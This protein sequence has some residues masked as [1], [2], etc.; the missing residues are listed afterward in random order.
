M[1]VG[2]NKPIVLFVSG[3]YWTGMQ[4]LTS[5]TVRNLVDLC[6]KI[7]WNAPEDEPRCVE[8]N[9][10]EA[11]AAKVDGSERQIIVGTSE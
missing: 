2:D 8:R 9:M 3:L 10:D 1:V 11:L 6:I 4:T 7:V 5:K